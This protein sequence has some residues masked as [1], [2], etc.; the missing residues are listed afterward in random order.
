MIAKNVTSADVRRALAAAN[1]F[2]DG[3]LIFAS[4]PK[5]VAGGGVRFRL[6]VRDSEG[7]GARLGKPRRDGRPGMRLAFACWHAHGRFFD[8][9]FA[10]SQEAEVTSKLGPVSP[11]IGWVDLVVPG[12]DELKLSDLCECRGERR[13]R[14]AVIFGRK[15]SDKPASR[16]RVGVKARGSLLG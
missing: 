12:H 4:G 10:A 11:G 8:A 1:E 13:R 15:P 5:V 6:R 2:Y 7:P 16:R 14:G 3:N 9:L